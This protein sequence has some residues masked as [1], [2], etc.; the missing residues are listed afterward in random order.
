MCTNGPLII[1]A[2]GPLFG[3]WPLSFFVSSRDRGPRHFMLQNWSKTCKKT[4]Y[5]QN[6]CANVKTTNN[7]AEVRM[8][9]DFDIKFMPLSKLNRG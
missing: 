6:I 2:F 8:V 3:L 1:M 5:L 7:W 4:K 9:S